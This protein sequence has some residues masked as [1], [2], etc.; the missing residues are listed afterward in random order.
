MLSD[1]VSW[2]EKVDDLFW[3]IRDKSQILR[4]FC[5]KSSH[6]LILTLYSVHKL[7]RRDDSSFCAR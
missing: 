5:K 1:T 4:N 7:H 2:F 6:R 3:K